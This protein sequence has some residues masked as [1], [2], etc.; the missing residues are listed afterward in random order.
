M[1][2]IN[3]VNSPPE[4][5]TSSKFL[6]AVNANCYRE[7]YNISFGKNP[8]KLP[9]TILAEMSEKGMLNLYSEKCEK[10]T[11]GSHNSDET[12][13]YTSHVVVSSEV[14]TEK[15]TGTFNDKA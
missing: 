6:F 15:Y 5:V 8:T 9:K 4:A 12:W 10:L 3:V 11:V 1:L 13:H 14:V 2:S 7:V